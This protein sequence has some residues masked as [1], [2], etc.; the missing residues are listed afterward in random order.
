MR[1]NLCIAMLQKNLFLGV[2]YVLRL[3][4]NVFCDVPQI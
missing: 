1:G 4:L 2:D 3:A